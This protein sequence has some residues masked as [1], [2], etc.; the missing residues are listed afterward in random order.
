MYDEAFVFD[1]QEIIN[2]IKAEFKTM[3]P[4]LTVEIVKSDFQVK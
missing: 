2:D 1:M 4:N 3:E